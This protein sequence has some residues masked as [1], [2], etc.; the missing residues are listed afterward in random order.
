MAE[1]IIGLHHL[2]GLLNLFVLLTFS[3]LQIQCL[4][5]LYTIELFLSVGLIV[6]MYY[7]LSILIRSTYSHDYNYSDIYFIMSIIRCDSI[8]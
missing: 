6:D 3:M 7:S 8:K 1:E 5:I 2:E 4:H